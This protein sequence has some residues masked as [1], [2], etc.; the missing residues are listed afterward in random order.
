MIP[1]LGI[2]L[3]EKPIVLATQSTSFHLFLFLFFFGGGWVF[4]GN[5]SRRLTSLGK[6]FG[7][8]AAT[9]VIL[10]EMSENG[11]TMVWASRVLHYVRVNI[12]GGI[13]ALMALLFP[14]PKFATWNAALR[15]EVTL[16]L[17]PPPP[18]LT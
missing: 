8:L 6:K 3:S 17:H 1:F 14:Y 4:L 10:G 5:R 16:P 2:E 13:F 7:C 12:E 11:L 15:V 18:P 9:V